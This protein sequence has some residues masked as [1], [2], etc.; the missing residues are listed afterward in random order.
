VFLRGNGG[1][2]RAPSGNLIA[3]PVARRDPLCSVGFSPIVPH[4]PGL[5]NDTIY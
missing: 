4:N 5:T 2:R 3:T 1:R